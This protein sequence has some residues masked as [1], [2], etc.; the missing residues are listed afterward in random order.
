MGVRSL[1]LMGKERCRSG[2]TATAGPLR[3]MSLSQRSSAV[4]GRR[5]P[6]SSSTSRLS[7]RNN[8]PG[9]GRLDVSGFDVHGSIAAVFAAVLG[10]LRV[11]IITPKLRRTRCH[12]DGTA[13]YAGNLVADLPLDKRILHP[14]TAAAGGDPG[15]KSIPLPRRS[16]L[17]YFALRAAF[18]LGLRTAVLFARRTAALVRHAAQRQPPFLMK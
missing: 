4:H 13:D 10:M 2:A 18:V 7:K 17:P 8:D 14:G 15:R 11:F 5:L 6:P 9:G 1:Q 12:L 16:G 3:Q